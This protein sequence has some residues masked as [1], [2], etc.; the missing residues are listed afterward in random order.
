MKLSKLEKEK[1]EEQ[2]LITAAKC[3]VKLD[4]NPN[5]LIVIPLAIGTGVLLGLVPN[6]VEYLMRHPEYTKTINDYIKIFY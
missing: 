4:D 1:F 6:V 3:G 2:M 5:P